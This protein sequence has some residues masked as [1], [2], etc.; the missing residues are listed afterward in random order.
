[1]RVNDVP[2]DAGAVVLTT[3]IEAGVLPH[4]YDLV[5]VELHCTDVGAAG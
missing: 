4:A 2:V 1:M 5:S 3:S